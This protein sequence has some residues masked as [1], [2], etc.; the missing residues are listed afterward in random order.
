MVLRKKVN[1]YSCQIND[2]YKLLSKTGQSFLGYQGYT[3]QERQNSSED[4]NVMLKL[5]R[6]ILGKYRYTSVE[7]AVRCLVP[8]WL[9]N[10]ANFPIS[11]P[12]RV[13]SGKNKKERCLL[14]WQPQTIVDF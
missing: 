14:L 2:Q 1:K 7:L 12:V 9:S 13:I 3:E 11:N 10:I 5:Y 4:L 8:R 6:I